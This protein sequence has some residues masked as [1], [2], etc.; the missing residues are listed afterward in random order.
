MTE[1]PTGTVTFLFTDLEGSTRLW[2][3]Q[4]AAMQ[5]VLA[6]HDEPRDD[7][8]QPRWAPATEPCPPGRDCRLVQ[9]NLSQ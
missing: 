1:L 8:P 6:R 4:P 5:V 9:A 3:E 7:V 2:E